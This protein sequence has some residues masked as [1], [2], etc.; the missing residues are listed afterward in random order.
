MASRQT[1]STDAE[2][3][4]ATRLGVGGS[5]VTTTEGWEA[6]YQT[7][8]TDSRTPAEREADARAAAAARRAKWW[9]VAAIT[10]GTAAAL[11]VFS[12]GVLYADLRRPATSVTVVA[13]PAISVAPTAPTPTPSAT[14][15]SPVKVIVQ[16][17]A[18]VPKVAQP[19]GAVRGAP[20]VQLSLPALGIDQ[21]LV[22]LRVRADQQLDVPQSYD[23]I[24]WWSTGPVPGDP[25]AAL[26]VGHLDSKDGPAVFNRL[27]SVKKGAIV[28]VRRADGTRVKFAVTKV[29]SFRKDDF[30]DELVY[31][32]DG[33]PSLHLLTCGGTYSPSG[34]YRDNVVVFAELI[35]PKTPAKAAQP[36][37]KPTAKPKAK[38][39]AKAKAKPTARAKAKTSAQAKGS[40]KAKSEGSAQP[41]GSS[42]A[43]KAIDKA[44]QKGRTG[45]A[46]SE[47]AEK[48][49]SQ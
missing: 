37:A 9:R 45:A 2:T 23:D 22:G 25:G 43:N 42:S 4:S 21:R 11:A 33:R 48:R 27:P 7:S 20:P 41:E 24:G 35:K 19:V 44:Y 5:D 12:S 16:A 29:Q 14:A 28:S 18:D 13:Q 36:K 40:A 39:T 6:W 46:K 30:P 8:R 34:G 1:N 3:G 38:A 17:P 15:P 32:T 31:R 47:P 10:T 26:M 49:R